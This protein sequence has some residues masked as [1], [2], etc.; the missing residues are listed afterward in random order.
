MPLWKSIIIFKLKLP[1]PALPSS[2]TICEIDK[3]SFS[4][5]SIMHDRKAGH[6]YVLLSSGTK[7]KL[8]WCKWIHKA[9]ASAVGLVY[10]WV[11]PKVRRQSPPYIFNENKELKPISWYTSMNMRGVFRKWLESIQKYRN[12]STFCKAWYAAA[13]HVTRHLCIYTYIIA[14][15]LII[16]NSR[17]CFI[18][19]FILFHYM[20]TIIS[21]TIIIMETI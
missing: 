5:D 4:P 6:L 21:N 12:Y 20:S 9:D 15:L 16:L 7:E 3:L 2:S 13:G 1:V 18:L 10:T 8:P 19:Y 17:V 14:Y 11:V